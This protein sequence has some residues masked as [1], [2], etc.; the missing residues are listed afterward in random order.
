MVRHSSQC[1][2]AKL[3]IIQEVASKLISTT[4][5]TDANGNKINQYDFYFNSLDLL[6]MDPVRQ[7]SKEFE[8]LKRYTHGTHGKTHH[9]NCRVTA[10]F[11]VER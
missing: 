7:D 1:S 5:H 8:A 4:N 6:S 10:A 3:I 9:F 2:G 11:R